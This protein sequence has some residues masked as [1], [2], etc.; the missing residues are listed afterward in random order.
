MSAP[1]DKHSE[2][3]VENASDKPFLLECDTI[4][5]APYFLATLTVLSLLPSFM[6]SV[7]IFVIPFIFFGS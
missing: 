3:P 5:L 7:S 6:I 1:R 2:I 4:C